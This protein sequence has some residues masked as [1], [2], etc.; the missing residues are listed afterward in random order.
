MQSDVHAPQCLSRAS[1]LY[2][3]YASLLQYSCQLDSYR[4]ILA[5]EEQYSVLCITMYAR[6]GL[7]EHPLGTYTAYSVDHRDHKM[8]RFSSL[9][10]NIIKMLII[11]RR[12]E[13][14]SHMDTT[15]SL[16]PH[17]LELTSFL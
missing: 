13:Y 2:S 5:H 10:N 4:D 1:P 3:Q 11:V 12:K 15:R 14:V 9:L 17:P 7:S 8:V 6:R 16:H